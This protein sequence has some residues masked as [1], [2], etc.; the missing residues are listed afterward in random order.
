MVGLVAFVD[1]R[2]FLYVDLTRRI[3]ELLC[4][5]KCLRRTTDTHIAA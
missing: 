2:G 4:F 5:E 3:V 1:S